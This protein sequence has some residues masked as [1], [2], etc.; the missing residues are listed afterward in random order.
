MTDQSITAEDCDMM[1]EGISRRGSDMNVN[2]RG[3]QMT[4]EIRLIV[5][6]AE[7]IKGRNT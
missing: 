3:R 6:K 7:C 4:D 5:E 2:I 1:E